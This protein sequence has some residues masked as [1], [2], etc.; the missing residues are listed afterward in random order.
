MLYSPK[1]RFYP[2]SSPT[3]YGENLVYDMKNGNI[4]EAIKEF[5]NMLDGFEQSYVD[6]GREQATQFFMK[7]HS[8]TL[9]KTLSIIGRRNLLL[10]LKQLDPDNNETYKSYLDKM[11]K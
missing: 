10:D 6:Y 1:T 2:E 4:D 11:S 8:E 3:L 5:N 7:I 9:A